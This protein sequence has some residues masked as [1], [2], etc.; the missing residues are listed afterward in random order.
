[1]NRR[2][3]L[4]LAGSSLA[5]LALTGCGGSDSSGDVPAKGSDIGTSTSSLGRIV[6]DGKGMTAYAFDK[7]TPGSGKSSCTGACAEEWPA[8]TTSSAKPK[9]DG[10]KG[11]VGT[12]TGADG[13]KQVTLEG[14]PLYTYA[15]DGKAGDTNGQGVGDI[16]WVVSPAGKKIQAAAE[17]GG[18]GGY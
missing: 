2:L 11:E 7:D 16:W 6:V 17:T 9:V 10:V 14:M 1:M 3:T 4:A 12:I 5:V 18:G 8:I 15:D 13:S